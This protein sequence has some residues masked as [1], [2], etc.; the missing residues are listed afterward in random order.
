MSGHI[1]DMVNRIKQNK[2]PKRRKFKGDNRELMYSGLSVESV[3]YNFP[4]MSATALEQLRAQ[5]RGHKRKDRIN[6]LLALIISAVI[7]SLLLIFFLEN[8]RI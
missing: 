4:E 6:T 5:I 7:I 8:Y 3:E 2:I 1:I